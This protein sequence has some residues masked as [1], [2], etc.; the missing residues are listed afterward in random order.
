MRRCNNCLMADTKPGL[1]LDGNGICQACIHAQMKK[2]TDYKKRF[3]ELRRLCDRYKRKDGYYDSIITVSGGKDSHFQVHVFKKLLGM[4]PL[5]ITVGDPFAKTKA[6]IHNIKNLCSVFNCDLISLQLSPDLVRRMVRI[7]FEELGSPTWPI[8]RAIYS[9]PMRMAIN[10]RIPLVVYGENVC[11][12]YGGVQQK[13]TYSA[14]E[15]IN[16]DVVK[17]VD[18]SLWYKNGINDKE[19]NMLNYPTA[20]EVK[21]SGL[22][23]IFLSYFIPWDGYRNYEVAKRYG[24]RDL[25]GEW[26]R[27][28]YIEDYVQIDSVAYL[29]NVWMR[30]P[31]FG[32]ARPTDVVGYWIRSGKI[33]KEE[34]KRLI[35]KHGHKL[36]KKIL[37]DFLEF[38]GYTAKGF[39]DIVER[40]WNRAIFEKTNGRWVLKK[41]Y[42]LK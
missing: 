17:P 32:Y 36:D 29:M 1:V 34:G 39:W 2:K 40:F 14:K 9:F 6:G 22:E 42:K 23:P 7:A 20:K 12:E 5:L 27:Q 28:G 33:T 8:D 16:N 3:R 18:F 38:T 11:W 41:A 25:G 26:K 15:Q 21:E 10:L 30:Y 31:K 4:N 35:N 13:E 24:F 37:N 19:L